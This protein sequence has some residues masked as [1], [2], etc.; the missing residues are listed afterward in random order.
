MDAEKYTI[1]AKQ[2]RANGFRLFAENLADI[3]QIPPGSRVLD[4]GCG[5]GDVTKMLTYCTNLGTIIGIDPDAQMIEVAQKTN[6]DTRTSFQVGSILNPHEIPAGK[7]HL[8]T[9]C[10]VMHWIPNQ[11]EALMNIS[12]CLERGGT[13]LAHLFA[14]SEAER[15]LHDMLDNPEWAQYTNKVS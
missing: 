4:I 5:T 7:F 11:S 8:A 9:A 12:N 3:A 15:F 14:G 1:Y 10:A 6:V 13:F 2:Q